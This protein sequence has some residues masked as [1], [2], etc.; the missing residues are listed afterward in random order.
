MSSRSACPANWFLKQAFLEFSDSQSRRPVRDPQIEGQLLPSESEP[1]HSLA[2]SWPAAAGLLVAR[3]T[4]RTRATC[5][6]VPRLSRPPVNDV[7]CLTADQ[8]LSSFFDAVRQVYPSGSRFLEE[9]KMCLKELRQTLH[10]GS[11]WNET[12]VGRGWEA[13]AKALQSSS[14]PSRSILST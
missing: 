5:E 3:L 11:E 14:A 2:T 7:R 12:S 9:M 1:L 13:F 10:L 8:F 4:R 6:T